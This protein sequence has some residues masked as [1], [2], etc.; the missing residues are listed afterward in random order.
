MKVLKSFEDFFN[1]EE[2]PKRAAPN[3]SIPGDGSGTDQ[4]ISDDSGDGETELEPEET[5]E[6]E[7]AKD[8]Y[9]VTDKDKMRIKDIHDKAQGDKSKMRKLAETMCKLITDSSKALRRGMAAQE[10]NF[11]EI[12]KLFF[13]RAAELTGNMGG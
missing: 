8:P 13:A 9:V 6:L 1:D 10:M 12:A 4:F 7:E 11:N 2:A 5:E 3:V